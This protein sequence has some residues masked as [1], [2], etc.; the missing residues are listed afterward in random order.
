MEMCI[1]FVPCLKNGCLLNSTIGLYFVY[2]LW[3]FCEKLHADS[4]TLPMCTKC[5][6]K[7]AELF[8]NLLWTRNHK[9]FSARL[10]ANFLGNHHLINKLRPSDLIWQS[11]LLILVTI[12]RPY[13][14]WLIYILQNIFC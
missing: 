4:N 8:P 6:T 12:S 3:Y 13:G 9:R 11:R 14:G 5:R 2:N 7:N 10:K 1:N